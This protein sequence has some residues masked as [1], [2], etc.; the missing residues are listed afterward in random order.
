VFARLLCLSQKKYKTEW[1]LVTGSSSGIGKALAD[2]L[3]SQAIFTPACKSMLAQ[4][5]HSILADKTR[6]Q[7]L[8]VVVVALDD[9]LLAETHKELSKKST[10]GT[11]PTAEKR[12]AIMRHFSLQAFT[13]AD[14]LRWAGTQTWATWNTS[15]RRPT[16]S[17]SE[18]F[19]TTRAT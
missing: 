1:A 15:S 13:T 19:S 8:N 17:T 6:A 11:F 9:K 2:K 4:P 12:Q 10:T 7:G 18:L 16:I 5:T 3:L 14:S